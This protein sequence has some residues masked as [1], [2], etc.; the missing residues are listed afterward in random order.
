MRFFNTLAVAVLAAVA[1][2]DNKANPFNIPTN[3]YTFKVG[4]PTTLNWQPTTT[5]T[6]TL[7]L[8]WGAVTTAGSGTV[9]AS[10]LDNDG[11]Y[12]WDVPSK[13]E[14]QPDYTIKIVSDN[15]SD[16]YNFLGRFTVEDHH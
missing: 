3:G 2:A 14:A 15:D 16:D 4:E 8:Q 10:G 11:S 9:I 7:Y 5:G 13:L 6:V 1:Y 12:T